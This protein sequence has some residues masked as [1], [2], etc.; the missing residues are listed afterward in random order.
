[1]GE[2]KAVLDI[3]STELARFK[4]VDREQLEKMCKLLQRHLYS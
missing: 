1:M 4:E 2:V 3:D